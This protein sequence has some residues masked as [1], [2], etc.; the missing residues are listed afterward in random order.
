MR[1][2]LP[3]VT[4]SQPV[5][6]VFSA[7]NDGNGDDTGGGGKPDTIL[8]PATAKNV[9]TVGA[10]EQL[11]NI[12]NEVTNASTADQLST[13]W[14]PETDTSNQVA[15]FSSRGN[16]GIGTEGTYG[17]FKPD[18]VAPGTF[19]ISTRSQQWDELAYYNPTNYSYNTFADQVVNPDSLNSYSILRS[20][21]MPW[22]VVILVEANGHSPVP[23]PANLPIYVRQ[24]DFASH[25]RLRF[26]DHERSGF[27]STGR[28]G[29]LSSNSTE[30]RIFLC[31]RQHQQ[32]A[33]N[34]DLITIVITTNNN[35]ELF[36]SVEQFE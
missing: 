33:I 13:P 36:P 28:P 15:G 4:G 16:V 22:A 7:G 17:R 10:L 5:L 25:E 9:I 23:F 32:Y 29:E 31:R 1:D 24:A 35:R 20:R 14:Q 11:R 34:Y 26:C 2:A 18:V 21:T 8:S 12:T 27:H 19:V 6:F 3:E 30:R